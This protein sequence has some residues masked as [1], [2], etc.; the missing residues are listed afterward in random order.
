MN[1]GGDAFGDTS[2]A[3]VVALA[4][5]RGVDP[6]ELDDPLHDWLDPDALDAVVESM[7]SGHVTFEVG[8][9]RVLVDAEGSITVDP[10]E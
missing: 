8:T 7:E 3:V 6:L 4:D 10:V 1:Q 9:H 2:T 5:A